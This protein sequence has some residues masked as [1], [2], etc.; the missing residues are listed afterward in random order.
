MQ[1]T[2]GLEGATSEGSPL[3]IESIDSEGNIE[4]VEL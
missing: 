4:R 2:L 1:E 3:I